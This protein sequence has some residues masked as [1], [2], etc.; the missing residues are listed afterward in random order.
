MINF[1]GQNLLTNL[2]TITSAGSLTLGTSWGTFTTTG[3][4][5][6]NGTLSVG[7][8]TSSSWIPPTASPISPAVRTL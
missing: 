5:T 2:A 6:N 8:A 1:G 7:A 3:N 4:F